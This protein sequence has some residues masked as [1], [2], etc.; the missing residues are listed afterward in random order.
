VRG[1]KRSLDADIASANAQGGTPDPRLR[2]ELLRKLSIGGA[3]CELPLA[4][5]AFYLLAGGER[6]WFVAAACVSFALRLSYRPFTA[7]R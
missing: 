2:A 6:R 5:G 3:L 4:L 1:F 7:R